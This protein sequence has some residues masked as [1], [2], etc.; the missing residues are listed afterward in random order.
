M[1]FHK[2]KPHDFPFLAI[3]HIFGGYENSFYFNVNV[4]SLLQAWLT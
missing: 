1:I 4:E 2:W 3:M